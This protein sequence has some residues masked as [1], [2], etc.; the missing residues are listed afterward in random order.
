MEISSIDGNIARV[1]ADG[2]TQNIGLDI[3]DTR[4]ALGDRVVVHAGFALH[5]VDK[6]AEEN[7]LGAIHELLEHA[8][9]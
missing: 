3:I 2:L 4:P 5:L 1:S 7:S 6:A 8:K 9:P